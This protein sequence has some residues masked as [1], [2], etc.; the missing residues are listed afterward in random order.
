[1]YSSGVVLVA[2]RLGKCPKLMYQQCNLPLKQHR[3]R[4][5]PYW[6]LRS[7]PSGGSPWCKRMFYTVEGKQRKTL[8][9]RGIY[10][11]QHNL[12]QLNA[13]KSVVVR[14]WE[15][16]ACIVEY[17]TGSLY[18]LSVYLLPLFKQDEPSNIALPHSPPLPK[19]V[20]FWLVSSDN[21]DDRE[22]GCCFGGHWNLP[23]NWFMKK[24]CLSSIVYLYSLHLQEGSHLKGL[25]PDEQLTLQLYAVEH[26][27]PTLRLDTE[28]VLPLVQEVTVLRE[29]C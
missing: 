11:R 7:V 25:L 28:A 3:S 27:L 9:T 26:V 8:V 12:P 1:M 24:F 29:P 23:G 18:H 15:G 13:H 10:N 2:L 22:L 17:A 6:S 19:R 4:Q 16:L 14:G 20:W 21:F 5:S